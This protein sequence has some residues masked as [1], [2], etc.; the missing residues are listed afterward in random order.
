M[1]TAKFNFIYCGPLISHGRSGKDLSLPLTERRGINGTRYECIDA[2]VAQAQ[3]IKSSQLNVSAIVSTWY[4]G[5][6]TDDNKKQLEEKGIETK[7]VAKIP[8]PTRNIH[9]KNKYRQFF[10]LYQA[11]KEIDDNEWIVKLRTDQTYPISQWLSYIQNEKFEKDKMYIAFI[12]CNYSFMP[13]FYFIAQ[14]G[15]LKS[16]LINF[17]SYGMHLELQRSI[18][19]DFPLKSY[20]GRAKKINSLIFSKKLDM[21]SHSYRRSVFNKILQSYIVLPFDLH[22]ITWRGEVLEYSDSLYTKN[23]INSD[24][25][26]L[27]ID[28]KYADLLIEEMI[29]N[30]AHIGFA[31]PWRFVR[32]IFKLWL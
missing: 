18:H 3:K 11:I 28:A 9:D 24:Y 25:R 16:K 29:N 32:N 20:F 4:E 27:H 30:E 5:R 26:G 14:C 6:T 21:R 17:L 19:A 15:L 23:L 7:I 2:L 8:D 1:S 12:G 31:Y 13:D 22:P 10:L